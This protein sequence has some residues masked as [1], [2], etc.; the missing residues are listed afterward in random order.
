MNAN[1][2]VYI[3]TLLYRQS[4]STVLK[5][6]LYQI[7]YTTGGKTHVNEVGREDLVI[8]TPHS[9]K[10]MHTPSVVSYR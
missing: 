10:P 4:H 3:V 1:F 5:S 2:N 7:H 8:P 9:T 6:A